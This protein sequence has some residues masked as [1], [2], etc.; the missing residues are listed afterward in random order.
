MRP[1]VGF[2]FNSGMETQLPQIALAWAELEPHR[3][4]GVA[5]LVPPPRINKLAK[6]QGNQHT[7]HDDCHFAEERAPAVKRT[8]KF[9]KHV[10]GP[11]GGDGS[12][13]RRTYVRNRQWMVLG[14]AVSAPKRRRPAD[15]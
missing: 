9:E 13:N 3:G 14:L 11:P 2:A 15:C 8:R 4:F 10:A 1:A 5:D 12:G 6:C 7:E